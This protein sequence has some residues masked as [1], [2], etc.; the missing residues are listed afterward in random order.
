MMEQSHS[1]TQY[2]C[3]SIDF[4]VFSELT[5]PRINSSPIQFQFTWILNQRSIQMQLKL[6]C[7][8]KIATS[9]L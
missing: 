4:C 5:T 7:E 1:D 9:N 6:M 8:K 3:H 2:L